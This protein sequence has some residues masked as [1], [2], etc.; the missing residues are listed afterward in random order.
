MNSLSRRNFIGTTAGAMGAASLASLGA[1]TL[2]STAAGA[3]IPAEPKKPK[4]I[5]T[6]MLTAPVRDLPF[7]EVLNMA[8][9]CHIAAL[10]VVAEPGH[11]HIDPGTFDAAQADSIKA[12][13][14]ERGL[15]ISAL[16]NYMDCTAPG[17]AAEVQE[18]LNKTIDAAALLGAPT[19]C[20]GL[21][22]P[23]GGKSKV[24]MIKEV[25]PGLFRPVI[26]HAKEKGIKV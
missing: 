15:E 23:V 22:M 5:R 19:I 24:Q 8:K 10:E 14:S 20:V 16:S 9:R 26:D 4:D 1:P 13:L 21:G 17:R 2:A 18:I 3:E 11:P 25:I 12:K 7:E 6:G